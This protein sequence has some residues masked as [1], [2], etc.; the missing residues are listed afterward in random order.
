MAPAAVGAKP[1]T[2]VVPGVA[3]T[4]PASLRANSPFRSRNS[5]TAAISRMPASMRNPA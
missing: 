3:C 4:A 2:K 5:P 1:F